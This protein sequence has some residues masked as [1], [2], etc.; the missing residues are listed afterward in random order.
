[1]K[2]ILCLSWVIIWVKGL[3]FP[4]DMYH[5]PDPAGFQDLLTGNGYEIRE[6]QN[7]KIMK[8]ALAD[9]MPWEC[10]E[11][12]EMQIHELPDL[13]RVAVNGRTYTQAHWQGGR[14]YAT[15]ADYDRACQCPL[16]YK[17]IWRPFWGK[18]KIFSPEQRG[19]HQEVETTQIRVVDENEYIVFKE[20]DSEIAYHTSNIPTKVKEDARIYDLNIKRLTERVWGTRTARRRY[21]ARKERERRRQ[22]P[23]TMAVPATGRPLNSEERSE[24]R[25]TIDRN[26]EDNLRLWNAAMAIGGPPIRGLGREVGPSRGRI[27]TVITALRSTGNYV[28]AKI[29]LDDI[30]MQLK[31]ID[32]MINVLYEKYQW[33]EW[34]VTLIDKNKISKRWRNEDREEPCQISEEENWGIKYMRGTEGHLRVCD[35]HQYSLTVNASEEGFTMI[36]PIGKFEP[37]NPSEDHRYEL[38]ERNETVTWTF[39][40]AYMMYSYL[41]QVNFKHGQRRARSTKIW[42]IMNWE[43]VYSR[44]HKTFLAPPHW[45]MHTTTIVKSRIDEMCSRDAYVKKIRR[46]SLEERPTRGAEEYM[47]LQVIHEQQPGQCENVYEQKDNC[48]KSQDYGYCRHATGP[49]EVATKR[50]KVIPDVY[51]NESIIA[52]GQPCFLHNNYTRQ[53]KGR[54]KKFFLTLLFSAI[55]G[56]IVEATLKSALDAQ[57]DKYNEILNKRLG[58]LSEEMNRGLGNLAHRIDQVREQQIQMQHELS[59][60]ARYTSDLAGRESDFEHQQVALNKQLIEA[61]VRNSRGIMENRQLALHAGEATAQAAI[62]NYHLHRRMIAL[63]EHLEPIPGLKNNTIYKNRIKKG[64]IATTSL[65]WFGKNLTEWLKYKNETQDIIRVEENIREE[66]QLL[67]EEQKLNNTVVATIANE[68]EIQKIENATLQTLEPWEF[69]IKWDP[70]TIEFVDANWTGGA[71]KVLRSVLDFGGKVVD[72]VSGVVNNVVDKGADVI[73]HTEDTVSGFFSGPIKMI[74]IIVGTIIGIILVLLFGSCALRYYKTGKTPNTKKA[75]Q[76]A[77]TIGNLN[78]VSVAGALA[79][80]NS[81]STV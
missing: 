17:V 45:K 18:Y 23:M 78:P 41:L 70:I 43:N 67:V 42:A 48:R 51:N 46:L 58:A 20:L 73:E 65:Y 81:T 59:L 77:T 36:L 2:I 61:M 28:Y 19:G 33:V 74:I 54:Q 39:L 15:V 44:F 50:H 80:N 7:K 66:Q 34:K 76:L 29:L 11:A 10:P 3:P 57:M 8:T 9:L 49:I 64:L 35:Y 56:G 31:M 14:Y 69:T 71:E 13:G 21:M 32:Y 62:M 26:R 6:L 38:F 22:E 47:W 79:S 60:L 16:L 37:A 40:D 72:D 4:E 75:L 25:Q 5:T 12:S 55:M 63:L 1:M 52:Y 53:E 68:W 27:S 24:D 30:R